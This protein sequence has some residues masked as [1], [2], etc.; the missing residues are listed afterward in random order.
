[1]RHHVRIRRFLNRPG[2]HAGAYVHAVV[3]DSS[4][5]VEPDCT[6]DWCVDVD[7]TIADCSRIVSLDFEIGTAA[8]RRNS[9]HKVDTLIDALGQFREAL[10]VESDRAAARARPRRRRT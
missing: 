5:C 8:E 2:H 7:L 6:H 1:M 3:G 10:V 9:L 4:T